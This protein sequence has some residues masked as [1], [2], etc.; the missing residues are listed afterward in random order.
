MIVSEKTFLRIYLVLAVVVLATPVL[1]MMLYSLD[2]SQLPS[3]PIR[4][5]SLH[6][7]EE[8]WNNPDIREGLST[9]LVVGAS[10]SL[11]ST[12]LGLVS[13][14]WLCRRFSQAKANA[15][16][17]FVSLPCF[18][19]LLLAGVAM[20]MYFQTIKLSGN[21][22]AIIVAHTC[23]CSPFALALIR[24]SYERLNP[25]LEAAAQ[26]LGASRLRTIVSVTVPQLWP[27]ITAAALLSFLVSWDEFIMS[28]F[29][30][31]FTKTLPMV[32]YDMIGSS[33][34]PSINAVG[35]LVILVS[36]LLLFT[37]VILSQ[38]ST[39]TNVAK[40]GHEV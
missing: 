14:Y 22:G 1:C 23:Y 39:R 17:A 25:E 26:N 11:L 38:K 30:G 40:A 13:S 31:G 20:L 3:V 19:P 21:I 16:L 6:W 32:L 8:A 4:S 29:V 10:V 12:L 33:Y 28:W 27:A 37:V 35:T 18:A 24:M 36:G 15:Y 34:N 9:S 2:A 5:Y 7:Y